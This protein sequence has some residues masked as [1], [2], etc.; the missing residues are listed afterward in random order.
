MRKTM[1]YL[2]ATAMS[3]LM[4]ASVAQAEMVA[5]VTGESARIS[6]QSATT[7]THAHHAAP[8]VP[9]RFIIDIPNPVPRKPNA[10]TYHV[11]LGSHQMTVEMLRVPQNRLEVIRFYR[12]TLPASGWT[13]QELPWQRY[14]RAQ[15]ERLTGMLEAGA[16]APEHRAQVEARIR[17]MV[18]SQKELAAQVF[19]Q[20]D[21]NQLIVNVLESGPGAQVFL[22]YWTD[23]GPQADS[24]ELLRHNPWMQTNV[25]CTDEMAQSPDEAKKFG[26]PVYPGA[27]VLTKAQPSQETGMTWLMVIDGGAEQV[28]A[29]YRQ[30]MLL[31]HWQLRDEQAAGSKTLLHFNQP[32]KGQRA[33]ITVHELSDGQSWAV[34]SL[35]RGAPAWQEGVTR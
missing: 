23:Q 18:V 25:L 33:L 13:L 32:E 29:F 10:E 5:P 27:K 30:G 15:M 17:Q 22:N 35:T 28:N 11:W 2:L 31:N 20:K 26:I 12:Q 16:V 7:E 24:A 6:Q 3:V 34:V 9:N 1:R 8:A 19:A 21:G 14:L 4:V